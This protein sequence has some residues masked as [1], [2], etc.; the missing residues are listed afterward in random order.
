[1]RSAVRH[2]W[3]S[4]YCA[5][6]IPSGKPELWNGSS[7]KAAVVTGVNCGMSAEVMGWILMPIVICCFRLVAV[8]DRCSR[9]GDLVDQKYSFKTG[10]VVES[11]SQISN[12]A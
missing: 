10:H 11:Y 3:Y 5:G 1:M 12:S 2:A 8:P 9:R 7:R 4:L 6:V